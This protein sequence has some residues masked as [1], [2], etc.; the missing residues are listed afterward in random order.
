[1]RNKKLHLKTNVI[2]LQQKT[3]YAGIQ[4][5]TIRTGTT[6][7][8]VMKQKMKEVLHVA[9]F[10]KYFIVLVHKTIKYFCGSV[11][12]KYCGLIMYLTFFW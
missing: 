12:V 2:T 3:N 7:T 1:M 8:E 11:N 9:S 10:R 4:S 5:L 6:V